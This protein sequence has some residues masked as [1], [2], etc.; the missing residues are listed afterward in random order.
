MKEIEI[1]ENIIADENRIRPDASEVDRLCADVTK[2]KTLLS[3]EPQFTLEK[4][5]QETIDWVVENKEIYRPD[6]YNV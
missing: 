1:E 4:G 6:I 2:A 5:L 3:W